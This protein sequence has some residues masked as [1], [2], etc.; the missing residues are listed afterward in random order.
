VGTSIQNF[1]AVLLIGIVAGTFSSIGIAP[2]L[3][4]VW[5][6]GEWGRF[7]QWLPL[8]GKS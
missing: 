7:R 5:E 2:S 3:L 1:A 6:R 4:V 8:R